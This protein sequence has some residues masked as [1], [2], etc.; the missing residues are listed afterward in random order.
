MILRNADG[1]ALTVAPAVVCATAALFALVRWATLPGRTSQTVRTRVVLG[2]GLAIAVAMIGAG[3]LLRDWKVA[4]AVNRI[5][6]D[7]RNGRS[8]VT[9]I[10]SVM[11]RGSLA[12]RPVLDALANPGLQRET[13][14]ILHSLLVQMR[15]VDLG[16]EPGAWDAWCTE[17]RAA[18][19]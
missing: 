1:Q 6:A 13:Q 15:G 7:V 10:E 14:F 19:R 5:D 3:I 17:V 4:R 8:T 9:D 12:C 2:V 11:R 18:Q 16:P